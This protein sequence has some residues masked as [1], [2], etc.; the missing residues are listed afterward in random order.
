MAIIGLPGSGRSALFEAVTA[1]RGEAMPSPVRI[2]VAHVQ[3]TRLKALAALLNPRKT[4]PAEVRYADV[5]PPPP[6]WRG[7]ILSRLG[8]V[9]AFLLVVR[10][11]AD[12]RVPHPE[13]SVDPHRDMAAM[14]WE[15][16][17]ADLALLE[18]RLERIREQ[19]HKGKPQEREAMD[20]E[21]LLLSRLKAGLEQ[22]VP[23]REQAINA[24]EARLLEGFPLLST[25]PLLVVVNIGE[26]DL[27]QAATVEATW[28]QRYR[29]PGHQFI[30]LSARLEMELCQLP[31]EEAAPFREAMG[32]PEPAVV[33]LVS[34]VYSLLGLATFF[35]TASSELRAWPVP[36]DTPAQR[37]AGKIH[38]DMERG[39]IRAEVVSLENLAKAGSLSEARRHGQM[40]L[41]GKTYPVQDGDIITFLFN[42]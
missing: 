19:G 24:E 30:V 41:E 39:F 35:T 31:A 34:L 3:D 12:D 7:D 36:K 9:D 17:F 13:G 14:E 22:K 28:R 8:N 18:R 42:I 29:R 32:V 25:R 16:V 38:S 33:R 26:E 21:Q 4:V 11:F 2:G 5:S 40:R 20:Q 10:A 15:L 37:A 6:D 27:T 23:L 1:G